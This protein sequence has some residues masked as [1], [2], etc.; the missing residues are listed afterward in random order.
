MVQDGLQD[1]FWM[2]LGSILGGFG[3]GFGLIFDSKIR[4]GVRVELGCSKSFWEHLF[5]VLG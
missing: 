4:L 1:A 3:E 2:A 5:E